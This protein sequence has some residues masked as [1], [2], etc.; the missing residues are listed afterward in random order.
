MVAILLAM[1]VGDN[2]RLL[3]RNRRQLMVLDRAFDRETAMITH[4][5]ERLGATVQSVTVQRVDHVNDATW[6]DVRFQLP[7]AGD[8]V[9]APPARRARRSLA[10]RQRR[11][12]RAPA[13][14][15]GHVRSGAVR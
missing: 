1:W 4:L 7:K 11:P 2:P 5:E 10:G 15:D 14:L 12:T 8:A 6:V 3:S 9:P 13:G